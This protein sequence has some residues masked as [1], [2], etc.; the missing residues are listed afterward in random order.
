MDI[1]RG[2]FLALMGPSGSGKTTLLNLVGALDRP[3]EGAIEIGGDRIDQMSRARP[4]AGGL[5][6]S[7]SSFSSTTSCRC[8][9]RS[10][11]PNC[12]CC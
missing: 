2:D 10:A 1:P 7:A 8:S 5:I 11:M 12:H 3:S 4:P 9:Q 6:M